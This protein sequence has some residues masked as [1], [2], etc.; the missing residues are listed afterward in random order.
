MASDT[1]IDVHRSRDG[2][3]IACGEIGGSLDAAG[4]LSIGLRPSSESGFS[5]IAFLSPA[6][7]D[8]TQTAISMFL[9]ETGVATAR[10]IATNVP[11]ATEEAEG[12]R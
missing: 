7:T 9:S 5:G 12:E 10:D 6:A 8:L 11:E 3:A 4:A 1:A 2:A